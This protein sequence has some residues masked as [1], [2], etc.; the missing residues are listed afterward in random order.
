MDWTKLAELQVTAAAAVG[1]LPGLTSLELS[2][3]AAA[4]LLPLGACRGLQK[5]TLRDC[6]VGGQVASLREAGILP[7]LTS[8][9]L[10]GKWWVQLR[11]LGPQTP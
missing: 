8:L 10:V 7:E 3:G 6:A 1:A 2:V 9:E 11:A 5:L 4:P